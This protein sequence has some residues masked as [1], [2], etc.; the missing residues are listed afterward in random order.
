MP[1][2]RHVLTGLLTIPTGFALSARAELITTDDG[3]PSQSWFLNTFLHLPEDAAEA[4][5]QG[6]ILAVVWEQ[7]GCPGCIKL[8]EENFAQADIA[9]YAR[10][11]FNWVGLNIHGDREVTGLDGAV[12]TEKQVA[13]SSRTTFTPTVQFVALDPHPR[14]VARMPGYLEPPEFA[15]MLRFVA[16]GHW[17]SSDFHTYLK[18]RSGA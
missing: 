18:N 9:D 10:A 15:A 17:R 6:R 14:E 4:A 13:R 3:M 12:G 1:T 16:E 11:H 2:R 7:K 8:H 5:E